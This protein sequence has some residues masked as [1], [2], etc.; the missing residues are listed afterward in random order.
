MGVFRATAEVERDARVRTKGPGDK[1]TGLSTWTK[2][3]I[4]SDTEN[5]KVILAR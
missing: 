2:S 5:D 4:T 3:Q 1:G